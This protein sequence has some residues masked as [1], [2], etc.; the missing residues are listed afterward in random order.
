MLI[1]DRATVQSAQ[2]FPPPIR[3]PQP[4]EQGAG[5]NSG[6]I[7]LVFPRPAAL[8]PSE[9]PLV[10]S[11]IHMLAPCFPTGTIRHS[12]DPKVCLP[13]RPASV[14]RVPREFPVTSATIFSPGPTG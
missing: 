7:H 13:V 3:C 8:R 12:G 11:Q 5:D 10:P 2:G 14:N 4:V 1:I 6:F 9:T